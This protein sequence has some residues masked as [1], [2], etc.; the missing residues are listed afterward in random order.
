MQTLGTPLKIEVL[1][2]Y[3][4]T[5]GPY[6]HYDASAVKEAIQELLD[7]GAIQDTRY[8][9]EYNTTPLGA[10][11]VKA[12]CNVPPPKQVFIDEQGRV[13]EP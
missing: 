2:H 6:R 3:H 13:L 10:A 1:L 5:P 4:N 8:P 12:L 11:W 9:N 7:Q